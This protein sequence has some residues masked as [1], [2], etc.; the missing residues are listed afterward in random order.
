MF[1]LSCLSLLACRVSVEKSGNDLM[2]V[3]CASLAVFP[4]LLLVFGLCLSLLS[5]WLLCLSVFLLGTLS[6]PDLAGGRFSCAR[7]VSPVT[8]SDMF[9]DPLPLFLLG[10]LDPLPL[11]PGAPG[12][13]PSLPPGSLD[14]LPLPPG[15]P[16]PSLSSSW[17]PW[18]LPLSLLG[19]WTLPLSLL[20]PWTLPLSLL[21]P[22]DPPSLPP[23]V[24]AANVGAFGVVP[25]V[26]SAVFF[27]S[28]HSFF[29]VVFCCSDL[30]CSALQAIYPFF[31]LGYLAVDFLLVFYSSVCLSV[32]VG[33]W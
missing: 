10:S 22:L 26:C 29:C 5:V 15:V 2:R 6:L 13:S 11:P 28:F 23:G 4:W 21:G 3:P 31:C 7:E 16:G 25:E 14:P 32:L 8:S 9:S 24:P 1:A 20:G 18:T 27:P 33:P 30:H 12:P 19:P 17:G